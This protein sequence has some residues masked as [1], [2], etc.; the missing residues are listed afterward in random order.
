MITY[1]ANGSSVTELIVRRVVADAQR[2]HTKDAFFVM[3]H[4]QKTMIENLAIVV[5]VSLRRELLSS[6]D[7]PEHPTTLAGFPIKYDDSLPA[8]VIQLRRDG[9]IL[10]A[11]IKNLAVP[12]RL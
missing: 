2:A 4:A 3:S 7:I 10:I 8:D 12:K 11:M 9:N 1:D 6:P 5:G